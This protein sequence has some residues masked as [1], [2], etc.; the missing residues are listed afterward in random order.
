MDFSGLDNE[1]LLLLLKAVMAEATERGLAMQR[2]ASDVVL[3]AQ[4]VAHIKAEATQR[5]TQAEAERQRQRIARDAARRA[6]AEIAQRQQDS[7]AQKI[8]SNWRKRKA[9]GVALEQWGVKEDWQINCWCRGADVRIYVDGGGERTYEWKMCLYV[10]GNAYHPPG[11][12]EVESVNKITESSPLSTKAG[13][14]QFKCFLLAVNDRW[15]GLKVSNNDLS[16]FDGDPDPKHLQAYL[17]ALE[18][19]ERAHV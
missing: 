3:D 14:Q 10:T 5:A 15:N 16:G 17:Q 9:I 1:Q 4:E 18:I 13:R 6:E 19:E 7:E 2:A 11:S 8:Q 12:L